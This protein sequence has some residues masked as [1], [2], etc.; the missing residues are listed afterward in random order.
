MPDSQ[1]PPLDELR[2]FAR[3]VEVGAFARAARELGVPTSTVS[4]AVTR[5]EGAMGLRLLHRSTRALRVTAEG[6]ALYE[7]A[8]PHLLGLRDALRSADAHDAVP[9]GRLR[10]TAPADIATTFLADAVPAFLRELP[11]LELD[12]VATQRVA[13]LIKED[14]D[15]AVRAGVL[16]DSSL[17]ARRL[18]AVEGVLCAAPAYLRRHGGPRALAE[19]AKHDLVAFRATAGR[20]RWSLSSGKQERELDVRAR[21]SGDDFSF[22]RAALIAGAGVGLLPAPVAARD[23]ADGTLTRVLDAWSAP[24]GALFVVYPSSKHLPPKVV[25]FRDFLVA[26][27]ARFTAEGSRAGGPRERKRGRRV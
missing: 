21:V 9:R 17:V 1:L 13:D 27:F 4:R 8:A 10:V 25:A 15:V 23:L 18:G 5:L 26:R 16:R 20:T 7:R 12:L 3:V 11:H 6:Q 2:A 24:L 14:F 19:L 22:V